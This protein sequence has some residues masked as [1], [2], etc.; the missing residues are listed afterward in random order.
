[1]CR[2]GFNGRFCR[3][4]SAWERLLGYDRDELMSRPFIDFVHPDDCERTLRQNAVVRRGGQA[5]AFENRYRCKDGSYR[6]L[7][8]NAAP[9]DD[10]RVIYSVAVDITGFRQ[11]TAAAAT[12]AQLDA[13]L[14]EL[15]TA[16]PLLTICAWCR[17]LQGD[18]DASWS[19]ARYVAL[20]PHIRISHGLCPSCLETEIKP[21]I[22]QMS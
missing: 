14:T 7:A 3:L 13:L 19:I 15:K 16:G 10:E 20:H 5:L 12:A 1:L 21:Q 9:D 22:A 4:S 11:A 8:W 17:K 6:W 18:G 2:L